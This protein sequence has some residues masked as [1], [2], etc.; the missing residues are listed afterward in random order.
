MNHVGFQKFTG[1]LPRDVTGS[2]SEVDMTGSVTVTL[3][4]NAQEVYF[5]ASEFKRTPR[6][7]DGVTLGAIRRGDMVEWYP[8]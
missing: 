5:M 4:S 2:I 3:D 6:R 1:A 8:S 7:G